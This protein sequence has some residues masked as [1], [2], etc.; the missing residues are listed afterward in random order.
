V[1]VAKGEYRKE[2]LKAIDGCLKVKGAERPQ[3]VAQ[4]RSE[5]LGR[6]AIPEPPTQQSVDTPS[7]PSRSSPLTRRVSSPT[8]DGFP[9]RWL[10]VAAALM[11]V[12]GGAYGGYEFIRWQPDQPSNLDV[13]ARHK[14]VEAAQRQANLDADRQL[15]E[16]QARVAA[17]AEASRRVA[18]AEELRKVDEQRQAEA[19]RQA[20]EVVRRRNEEYERIAA[21]ETARRTTAAAANSRRQEEPPQIAAALSDDERA[22]LVRRVQQ[23]LE[24]RSCYT[25]SINGRTEDA[26]KALQRFVDGAERKGGTKPVRIELAKATTADFE[27]WL[28]DAE[29][30]KGDVCAVPRPPQPPQAVTQSRQ[31]DEPR[32]SPARTSS[33]RS[34]PPSGGG[35][36]AGT[37]QGIQ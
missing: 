15:K 27:S 2:F 31:R 8:R 17:E 18:E 7:I 32:K 12:V 35:R 5:L 22:T 1:R 19:K 34:S 20:E 24:S 30:V 3:S 21:E 36:A 10:A 6:N 37:M 4:L 25:G 26:Q 14:T 28:R 23:V 13:D 29:E 11:A 16:E 33:P 9:S